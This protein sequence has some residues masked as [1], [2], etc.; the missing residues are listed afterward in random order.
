MLSQYFLSFGPLVVFDLSMRPDGLYYI[1]YVYFFI[2]W[3]LSTNQSINQSINHSIRQKI[4][5]IAIMQKAFV[6][7]KLQFEGTAQVNL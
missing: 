4:K 2:R 1:I 6:K 3:T 5:T 7:L